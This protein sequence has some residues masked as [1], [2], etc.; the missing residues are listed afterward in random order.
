MDQEDDQ[1]LAQRKRERE[2]HRGQREERG[3]RDY[4]CPSS[5]Q[6]EEGGGGGGQIIPVSTHHSWVT[7]CY[8]LKDLTDLT[9]NGCYSQKFNDLCF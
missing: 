3:E 5:P 4:S 8:F 2:G 7:V 1:D 9:I 6:K